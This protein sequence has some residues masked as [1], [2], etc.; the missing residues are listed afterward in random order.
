MNGRHLRGNISVIV[1]VYNAVDYLEQCLN[2]IVRQT[3]TDLEIICINDGSTDGSGTLL[4]HFA[5]KDDRIIVVHQN[6]KGESSARNRGLDIASGKYLAFVDCDDWIEPE[7]YSAMVELAEKEN[8]DLVL[9]GYYLEYKDHSEEAINEWKVDETAFSRKK[10]FEYVYIRDKYRA[11]TSWIWCKLFNRHIIEKQSKIRFNESLR[12]GGDLLFFLEY[13]ERTKRSSYI[14][15]PFYHYL[16]R[17]K[18]TSHSKDLSL[19]YELVKTYQ[20]MISYCV[21]HSLEIESLPWLERFLGYRALVLARRSIEADD[22]KMFSK[23]KQIMGEVKD[24]YIHYNKEYAARIEEYNAIL[25][26]D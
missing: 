26:Q 19:Q 5:E 21:E 1:P 18:S 11:V 20:M 13:M 9:C 6:N 23:C 14:K 17:E 15:E 7:M 10:L 24:S 8:V 16:Q 3:Y 4:D 2:S 12:L 25:E 22:K